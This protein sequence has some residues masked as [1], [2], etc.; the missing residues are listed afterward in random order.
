MK[1]MDT[2]I[3]ESEV[4]DSLMVMRMLL[5]YNVNS[6]GV[7]VVVQAEEAKEAQ[8]VLDGVKFVKIMMDLES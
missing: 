4:V 3:Q 7:K 6:G 8:Y 5:H 1:L 2:P